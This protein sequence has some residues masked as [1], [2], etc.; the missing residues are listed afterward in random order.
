MTG[1]TLEE[2][3]QELK[4]RDGETHGL[5]IP[6]S[7]GGFILVLIIAGAAIQRLAGLANI[8]LSPDEA[9]QAVS[10]WAFWQPHSAGWIAAAE[11]PA[12]F[13]FSSVAALF[14]GFH[15]AT[16]RLA[17]A[18]AGILT[19]ASPWL[20]RSHLGIAGALTT[21][22]LLAVSP[23]ATIVARTASGD[24]F[25]VLAIVLL[26][27]SA[28]RFQDERNAGWFYLG[29]AALGF[30]LTTSQLFYGGLLTL[31]VS[32]LIMLFF[33][34]LDRGPI[35]ISTDARMA[36]RGIL[37][38]V[39]AFFV[40]ATL[41]FWRPGGVGEA[42]QLFALWLRGFGLPSD[43]TSW[44]SPLLVLG[45]YELVTIVLGAGA[46]LWAAWH[47]RPFALFFVYWFGAGLVLVLMQAGTLANVVLLMLPAYFLI[48][49][50]LQAAYEAS[51]SRWAF[52]VFVLVVTVGAV[53]YFNGARYIQIASYDASQLSYAV[54][55]LLALAFGLVS[56]NFLRTWNP[57]VVNKG[58]LFGLLA[59][60]MI[61]GWGSAWWLGQQ[62]AN[63]P[64]ERWVISATDDDIR[65]MV[66]TLSQVSDQITGAPHDVGGLVAAESPVLRWYLRDFVNL[67][68]GNTVPAGVSE[69]VI[70]AEAG[71][72]VAPDEAYFGRD[73][74]L[75]FNSLSGPVND[76][77]M[78]SGLRWLLFR[79]A[80]L[81]TP[82]EHVVLWVLNA[83]IN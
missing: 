63:D 29:S 8:P 62:A 53:V 33:G 44:V 47:G 3:S 77:R 74:A 20:L 5:A 11:S 38:G 22:A 48:G 18:L 82:S 52:A 27:A 51:N 78:A 79:Q 6:L 58:A 40:S 31:V 4:R 25:A 65:L 21:S 2:I 83:A 73:F 59:L 30:G 28:F 80:P 60:F 39:G 67:R 64:R 57:G 75:A 68:F 72:P 43:L 55:A 7:V 76:G 69:A 32:W 81:P 10:V 41:L 35:M 9:R 1:Q 34:R 14:L 13:T 46:I 45:R 70:I 19:V 54:L 24:S 37:I 23:V 17:P 61:F 36:R 26:L 42:A 66:R 12:H 16:V 50:W 71:D 56:L 49:L 15:D